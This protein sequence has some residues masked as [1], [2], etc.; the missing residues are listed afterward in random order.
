MEKIKTTL[1]SQVQIG[2]ILYA[3]I[4]IVL[5]VSIVLMIIFRKKITEAFNSQISIWVI[6]FILTGLFVWGG[7]K[8][9]CHILDYRCAMRDDFRYFSGI[10]TRYTW[11]SESN[12]PLEPNYGDVVLKSANRGEIMHFRLGK[13][14]LGQVYTVIYLPYTRI[15]KVCPS[16]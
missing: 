13:V 16:S 6:S 3:C 10:A 2:L 11:T 4:T 14:N 9:Y 7:I 15:A 5:C 1:I 8:L 12:D